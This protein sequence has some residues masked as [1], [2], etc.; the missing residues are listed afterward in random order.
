MSVIGIVDNN[1][2][3]LLI[4]IADINNCKHISAI[5]MADINNSN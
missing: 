1:N 4:I 3:T 2:S 5:R